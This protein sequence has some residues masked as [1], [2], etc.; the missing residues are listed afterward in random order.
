[1]H[2]EKPFTTGDTVRSPKEDIYPALQRTFGYSK[3]RPHQESVVE[4]LL[5][6]GDALVIMPSGGGKSLCYQLPATLMP[7]TC[8]V[9]SPLISLM[10]DQVDG[11][12]SNGLQ[13]ACFNSTMDNIER[14]NV[15]KRLSRRELD[16][17]YIS[18]ERLVMD[19]FKNEL[20]RADI[21]FFAID[22]A[23]CISEWGHDFRPD[24]LD[25]SKLKTDFPRV[26]IAAFTATAT[27]PVRRDI[28]DRLGLKEPHEVLA[29][30]NRPN[31]FYQVVPKQ[32]A[33]IQI[34]D[35]IQARPDESGIVYRTTRNDVDSTSAFLQ[36]EGISA[37]PYH[38]GLD[39]IER[40]RHQDAFCMG[41]V[42]VI[43]ATVAF[44]MGIDKPDV[45]YVI[46]G[47]L[48]KNLE[49]Y[50]QE[51]GRAGRDGLPAHCLLLFSESDAMKIRYFID[52]EEDPDRQRLSFKKLARIIEFGSI[53]ACRRRHLLAYFGEKYENDS[54]DSCDICT[55][56]TER[57]DATEDAQIV[58]SAI[59]RTR[60]RYG[61]GKIVDIVVGANTKDVRKLGLDKVKTY[62]VGADKPK[63]Y[64]RYIINELIGQEFL[65][66]TDDRY[67]VLILSEKGKEVLLGKR[68]FET[69]WCEID[70]T[71][72]VSS[73]EDKGDISYDIQL[74]EELRR[75]RREL[76]DEA[77]MP[78][79]AVFHDRTL[80][81]MAHLYP[82]TPGKLLDITGVG[83]VKLKNYGDIFMQA[84]KKHLSDM[85]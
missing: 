33:D 1:M 48:P 60:E 62:G 61:M 2:N 52:Q 19:L 16:L 82:T 81:E 49:S 78:P 76:A 50:Y 57:K 11:A 51:T 20:K 32:N 77:G 39:R 41:E 83:N 15:L 25:L 47:D 53:N 22:E 4:A 3:F 21:S 34:L 73:D 18:P 85:E 64:W 38:A 37:L 63:K 10:K 7:G 46:H 56:Q 75:I 24:Y 12:A 29:S 23:H 55:R 8:V 43:V 5:D 45:R 30:F 84:I 42:D 54:C 26:P 66:R 28:A 79:F 6:G 17:L 71:K 14:C 58:M 65:I 74:F 70:L 27:P 59:L 67:P 68:K 44:G 40:Q 9:V 31:F 35:F 13:A 36:G 69:A 80:K 72:S